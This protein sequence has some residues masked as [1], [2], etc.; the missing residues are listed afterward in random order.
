MTR[1]QV[2]EEQLSNAERK[3][4]IYGKALTLLTKSEH[5]K[6]NG[7]PE[8]EKSEFNP[9][10]GRF[11]CNDFKKYGKAVCRACWGNHFIKE[12]EGK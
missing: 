10:T 2:L 3:A 9:A 8:N 6:V 12:A 7:C 5:F 1:N 4:A 11:E